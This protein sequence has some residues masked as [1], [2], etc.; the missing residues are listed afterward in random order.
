MS[1]T[2]A[3]ATG[4]PT[5]GCKTCTC[6]NELVRDGVN[7]F[8][9]DETPQDFARGLSLLMDSEALRIQFGDV[10]KKD[11]LSYAPDVV[12]EMWEKLLASIVK[13]S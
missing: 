7:G 13:R 2:E 6:V 5:V 11:M 4:L 3:M 9:C 8:L 12:W 10:A 1:L